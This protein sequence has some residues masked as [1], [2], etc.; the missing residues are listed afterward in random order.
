[1][2]KEMEYSMN[3]KNVNKPH[4]SFWVIAI[5]MLVW[6]VMGCINFLVQMNPDM[7][8]SYRETEQAIIQGRPI[9]A[10]LAFAVAVFGGAIGCLFL[11][12]K[13]SIAFYMFIGSLIGVV[14]TMIH[15]LGAGI[16]FSAGELIGI[17]FMPVA[18][19]A[20]LIWYST[21]SESKCWVST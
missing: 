13:K 21:Y 12:L 5:F 11:I 2:Q 1:V 19:A 8:S 9:W 15:T 20:F 7:V 14:I 17:I 6:N 4:W 16:V 3:D 10:T 18:V